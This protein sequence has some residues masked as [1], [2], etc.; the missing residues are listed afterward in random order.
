MLNNK[1]AIVNYSDKIGQELV[2]LEAISNK[3]QAIRDELLVLQERTIESSDATKAANEVEYTTEQEDCWSDKFLGYVNSGLNRYLVAGKIYEMVFED[4]A[5]VGEHLQLLIKLYENSK[6]DYKYNYSNLA[7]LIVQDYKVGSKEFE[8][9][10]KRAYGVPFDCLIQVDVIRIKEVEGFTALKRN[11]K[12]RLV[13]DLE[14]FFPDQS[15]CTPAWVFSERLSEEIDNNNKIL[16]CNRV[17][18]SSNVDVTEIEYWRDWYDKDFSKKELVGFVEADLSKH[19]VVGVKYNFIIG[20]VHCVG[21]LLQMV[22][23]LYEN[24]QDGDS[25]VFER[26]LGLLV[27]NYRVGNRDFLQMAKAV[28]DP[29]IDML[30]EVNVDEIAKANGG[31]C[32]KESNGKLRLDWSKFDPYTMP[33]NRIWDYSNELYDQIE[34]NNRSQKQDLRKKVA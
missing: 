16:K 32:L 33:F 21:D 15:P 14:N 24:V 20:P 3:V 19:L 29:P 8:E 28:Y 4:A 23:L 10:A 6:N 17:K 30:I 9:F 27:E 7:G 25:F 26:P 13:V 5:M 31:I 34:A 18:N 11:A 12:G 22:V 1:N 2:S